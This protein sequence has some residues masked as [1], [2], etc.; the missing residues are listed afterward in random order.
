[1]E[2]RGERMMDRKQNAITRKIQEARK[3]RGYPSGTGVVILPLNTP[4]RGLQW[5]TNPLVNVAN[6]QRRLKEDP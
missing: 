1:M 2:P 4:S 3:L 6:G 5:V